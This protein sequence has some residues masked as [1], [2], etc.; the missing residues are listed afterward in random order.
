MWK[1][2]SLK[3]RDEPGFGMQKLLGT[4]LLFVTLKHIPTNIQN[5]F[6]P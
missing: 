4:G 1:R 5:Y 2:G 3:K 6:Q